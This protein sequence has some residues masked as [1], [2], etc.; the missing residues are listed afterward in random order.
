MRCAGMSNTDREGASARNRKRQQ[1][2]KKDVISKLF[3]DFNAAG[4]VPL[5]YQKKKTTLPRRQRDRHCRSLL[6]R[7]SD[8]LRE[9]LLFTANHASNLPCNSLKRCPSLDFIGHDLPV[10]SSFG[11]NADENKSSCGFGCFVLRAGALRSATK[12]SLH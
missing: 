1:W 12:L 4:H 7:R 6:P 11:N 5:L 3:P 2:R 8:P 9:F 10:R